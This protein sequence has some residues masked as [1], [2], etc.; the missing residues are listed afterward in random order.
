MPAR[1]RSSLL[2]HL[3]FCAVHSLTVRYTCQRVTSLN[4]VLSTDYYQHICVCIAYL[5]HCTP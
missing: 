3:E 1:M 4:A 2:Q 5:R